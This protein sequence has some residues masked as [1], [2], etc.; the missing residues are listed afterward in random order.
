MRWMIL[1]NI[2]EEKLK[3]EDHAIDELNKANL[4][5]E[6]GLPE[7]SSSWKIS[8]GHKFHPAALSNSGHEIFIGE[9]KKQ[10]L[11]DPQLASEPL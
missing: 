11:C 8:A 2:H 5:Q 1:W 7:G 3:D 6:H 10:A 9:F 4:S